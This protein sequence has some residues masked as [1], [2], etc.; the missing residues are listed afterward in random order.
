MAKQRK[1][2]GAQLRRWS[3]LIGVIVAAAV[4][5]QTGNVPLGKASGLVAEKTIELIVDEAEK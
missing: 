2:M 5:F 3:A 1:K 4:T